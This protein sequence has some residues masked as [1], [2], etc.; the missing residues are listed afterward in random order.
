MWPSRVGR[1]EGLPH[2]YI[3]MPFGLVGVA[4]AF[5]RYMRDAQTA[6]KARHQAVLAEM[7]EHL[8]EPLGPSESPEARYQSDS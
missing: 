5:Q 2:S 7:E 8:Q 1:C 6:C 4:E 3:Y